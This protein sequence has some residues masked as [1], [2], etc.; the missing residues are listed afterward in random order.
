MLPL[1]EIANYAI[2][3]AW[4]NFPARLTDGATALLRLS[5][6]HIACNR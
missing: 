4:P 6:S 3:T 2:E 1:I 5:A